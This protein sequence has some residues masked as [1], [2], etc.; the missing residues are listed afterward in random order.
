VANQDIPP[1]EYLKSMASSEHAKPISALGLANLAAPIVAAFV[2]VHGDNPHLVDAQSVA[3]AA[4]DIAA[5]LYQAAST[6]PV[7][8]GSSNFGEVALGAMRK[9]QPKR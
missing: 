8:T 7:V 4:V 6:S 5:R 9:K 2:T 3:N 1:N